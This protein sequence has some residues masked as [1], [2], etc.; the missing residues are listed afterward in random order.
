[1]WFGFTFGWVFSHLLKM[2]LEDFRSQRIAQPVRN[3]DTKKNMGQFFTRF[4]PQIWRSPTNNPP[5]KASSW[6]PKQ[7]WLEGLDKLDKFAMGLHNE[8]IW[9]VTCKCFGNAFRSYILHAGGMQQGIYHSTSSCQIRHIWCQ[10][11]LKSVLFGPRS[12]KWAIR[13]L[14]TNFFSETESL[15]TPF[16]QNFFHGSS[17]M[18]AHGVSTNELRQFPE[19]VARSFRR[20]R[21]RRAPKKLLRQSLALKNRI[22]DHL[23][24]RRFCPG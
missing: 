13:W 7:S 2:C 3:P 4:F 17:A 12:S 14:E 24:L 23:R 19:Q 5:M 16:D 1:M 15:W 6:I 20:T 11:A 8:K 10:I 21:W 22:P 9:K 18:V